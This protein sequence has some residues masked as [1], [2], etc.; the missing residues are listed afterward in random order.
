M[1]CMKCGKEISE[2]QVFCEDCL[3]VMEQYPVK[4]DTPVQIPKRP[5]RQE[6]KHTRQFSQKE[7]IRKQSRKIRMLTWVVVVLF[8]AL[9]LVGGLFLKQLTS[10]STPAIN[11]LGS[12]GPLGQNYTPTE[13]P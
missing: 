1:H 2:E 5:A 9:C 4:P 3:A 10:G 13:A 11:P 7:I 6:K 12:H 8:A